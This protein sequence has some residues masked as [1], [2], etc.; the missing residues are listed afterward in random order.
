MRRATISFLASVSSSGATLTQMS[1]RSSRWSLISR[2]S[3]FMVATRTTLTA[4]TSDMPSRSVRTVPEVTASS[5][6]TDRRSSIRLMSST[7]AYPPSASATRPFSRRA[8]PVS[9]R[10]SMS[11]EP[12]SLSTSAPG[13]MLTD[14][15]PERPSSDLQSTV[16]AEP[17]GPLMR[18]VRIPGLQMA[19]L[20]AFLAASMP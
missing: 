6:E 2:S 19:H 11:T 7:K 8:S 14:L 3:G 4:D 10:L 16:L 13:G 17:E 20:I 1:K 12:N 5:K 18:T 9:R 15:F